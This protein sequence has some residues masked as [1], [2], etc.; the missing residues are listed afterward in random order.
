[1]T[2]NV[3]VTSDSLTIDWYYQVHP[4]WTGEVPAIYLKN[5]SDGTNLFY[6]KEFT[7]EELTVLL[8]PFFL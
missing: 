7:E 3:F 6:Q 5:E 4:S 2:S 8:Q 1:M